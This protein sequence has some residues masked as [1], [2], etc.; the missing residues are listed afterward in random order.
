MQE[1]RE[2]LHL[3]V[4][5]TSSHPA[6]TLKPVLPPFQASN[7]MEEIIAACRDRLTQLHQEVPPFA[8]VP[9]PEP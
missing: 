4:T 9:D 8:P 6:H 3:E 1:T 2:A 7:A 5:V